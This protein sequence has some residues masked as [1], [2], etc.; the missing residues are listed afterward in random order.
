MVRKHTFAADG[1]GIVS[2]AVALRG[3]A[4]VLASPALLGPSGG[5]A[6][7]LASGASVLRD[8][9]VQVPPRTLQ[10]FD[11]S[12]RF[13]LTKL[14]G[15][16]FSRLGTR[17]LCRAG[18]CGGPGER[19]S[20]C[21]NNEKADELRSLASTVVLRARSVPMMVTVLHHA[22]LASLLGGVAA[23]GGGW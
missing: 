22:C 3:S 16:G 14:A 2:G 11:D 13:L 8:V 20:G 23:W 21:Y 6:D 5:M 17:I 19:R 4:R 7:A 18:P 10:V 1:I 9:G 12:A 15:S